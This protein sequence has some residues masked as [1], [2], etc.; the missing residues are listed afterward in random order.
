[1]ST[2]WH[3]IRNKQNAGT[4]LLHWHA[5]LYLDSKISCKWDVRVIHNNGVNTANDLEHVTFRIKGSRQCLFS[6]LIKIVSN[7][8]AM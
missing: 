5:D 2:K 1:M 6:N 3:S 8:S 4:T 7:T